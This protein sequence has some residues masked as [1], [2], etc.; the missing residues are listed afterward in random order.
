LLSSGA[1]S[2]WA[3]SGLPT[4]RLLCTL[5]TPGTWAAI[6]SAS[7]REASSETVPESVTSLWMVAAV[8]RSFFRGWEASSAFT[9][10]ISICASVRWPA[11]AAAPL[12]APAGAFWA[13]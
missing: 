8:M 11:V 6:D 4:V 2:F 10:S 3:C 12:E 7:L 5:V 9:T 1:G 13:S